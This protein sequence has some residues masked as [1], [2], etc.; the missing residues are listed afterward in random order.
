MVFQ[1]ISMP[2]G[3]LSHPNLCKNYLLNHK[4]GHVTFLD[5][6]LWWFL[7]YLPDKV[8]GMA[9][10]VLYYQTSTYFPTS[11]STTLQ[12]TLYFSHHKW[13]SQLIL[14]PFAPFSLCPESPF[15]SI[16]LTYFDY[17]LG[18]SWKVKSFSNT[19][20]LLQLLFQRRLFLQSQY[21]HSTFP[22]HLILHLLNWEFLLHM[23]RGSQ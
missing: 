21:F 9:W 10:E 4:S 5:K 2:F 18:P 17:L 20:P 16:Y 13:L 22:M 6:I 8:L 11:L 15:S 7:N 14:L 1:L 3:S 12:H 19:F 23:P